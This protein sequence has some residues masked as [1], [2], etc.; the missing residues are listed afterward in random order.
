MKGWV[1]ICVLHSPFSYHTR[2]NADNSGNLPVSRWLANRTLSSMNFVFGMLQS[3][4]IQTTWFLF[5]WY[6][7]PCQSVKSSLITADIGWSI[8]HTFYHVCI[9]MIY[10]RTCDLKQVDSLPPCNVVKDQTTWKHARTLSVLQENLNVMLWRLARNI[11]I[12]CLFWSI[13]TWSSI[14]ITSP[15]A[16]M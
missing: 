9:K 3:F 7:P 11:S 10:K 16:C 6:M 5:E 2:I 1:G 15:S 8:R 14:S 4:I 13:A 12:Q